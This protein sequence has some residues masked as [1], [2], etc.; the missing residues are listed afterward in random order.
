M[1]EDK[2]HERER[3]SAEQGVCLALYRSQGRS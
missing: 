2:S 1:C 3:A